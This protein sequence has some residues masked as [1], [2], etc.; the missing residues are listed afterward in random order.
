M[1]NEIIETTK[2]L[3]EQTQAGKQS[4]LLELTMLRQMGLIK[5]EEGEEVT[6]E[7]LAMAREA[8]RTRQMAQ[9]DDLKERVSTGLP[10]AAGIIQGIRSHQQRA[11]RRPLNTPDIPP[12]TPEEVAAQE[13]EKYEAPLSG[14][15]EPVKRVVEARQGPRIVQLDPVMVL[16]IELLAARKR[17][18]TAEERLA[19][20]AIQD[21]RKAK[22]ELE[23]EEHA[24]MSQVSKQL[25]IPAGKSI[26]VGDMVRISAA[27]VGGVYQVTKVDIVASPTELPLGMVISKL[28]TTRCVV[29][30]GGEV[31][32]I[33]SGLIPGKQLFIDSAGKLSH[34]VPNHPVTGVKSVHPA[35]QALSTDALFLRIQ[36]PSIIRA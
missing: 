26:R 8:L 28:T 35:A 36:V 6:E 12:G 11:P 13:W 30:V 1:E 9:L 32:G 5:R 2:E 23:A 7:E 18:N 17:A 22:Q 24:L 14:K 21:A 34:A 31:V 10:N 33:Y 19:I 4:K 15:S 27:A 16:K 20:L 3:I 25:N 29:Q